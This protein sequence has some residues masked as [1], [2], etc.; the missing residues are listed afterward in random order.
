M[1]GFSQPSWLG[2]GDSRVAAT[3]EA[4]FPEHANALPVRPQRIRTST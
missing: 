4:R 2:A 3:T 1:T